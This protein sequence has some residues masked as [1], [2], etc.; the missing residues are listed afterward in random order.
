MKRWDESSGEGKFNIA[1]AQNKSRKNKRSRPE[2]SDKKQSRTKNQKH[3]LK[4]LKQSSFNN[5]ETIKPTRGKG[6]STAIIE[7]DI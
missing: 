7:N 6:R 4:L 2:K 5:S 3:G 1:E